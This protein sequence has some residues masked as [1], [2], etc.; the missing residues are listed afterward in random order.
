MVEFFRPQIVVRIP[1]RNM[2]TKFE[3]I[4]HLKN[5]KFFGFQLSGDP[6]DEL[7]NIMKNKKV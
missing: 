6:G 3:R 4:K 2:S 5:M 1:T 7:E